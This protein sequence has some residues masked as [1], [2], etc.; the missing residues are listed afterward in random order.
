MLRDT[1]RTTLRPL[2]RRVVITGLGVVS[3]CGTGK[4]AFWRSVRDGVSGIR[5]IE[6]FDVSQLSS[7]IGGEVRDFDPLDYIE[8]RKARHQGRFVHFCVAAARLALADADLDPTRMEPS[9]IGAAFGSSGAGCGNIADEGYRTVFEQ[10]PKAA[11]SGLINE[12][13]AHAATSHVSIEFGLKGPC[14]SNSTGCV[15]SIVSVTNGV[16][17]LRRG[18]AKCMVVGASEACL[19]EFVFAVLC[20]QRVLSTAND[21][22]AG[23]CKPFDLD[24]DG[25][26]LGEGGA[27]LVLETA[28]HAM[29]RGARIYGEVVGIGFASEA[30]HMVMSIPT[31]E[32]LDRALR[33][34]LTEAR[35][36]PND[37]DYVCAHG[38]GN[39]QYDVADTRGYKLALGD[40]AYNIPV[41]SIK[42]VTAQPFAAA[43]L[44]QTLAAC[45]SFTEG[46]VPPT[47]NYKT[48]DPDCDLDYVPNTA[49]RARV[50]T[51]ALNSHSF[52]GTHAAM[53]LRRFEETDA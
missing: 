15:T 52:G 29:D 12:I 50:D 2:A 36:A 16:Q 48:P 25:L 13:P 6:S 11:Y 42:P 30:Y 34:A 10:G 24:R 45:M 4:D 28:A 31:G 20:R 33:D 40:H 23:A 19:S 43:G 21:D 3:C 18:D 37:V 14:L 8:E 17:V 1:G 39:K 7:Q 46:V 32:E 47:I 27:A 38:I 51:A 26:V 22:P 44:M 41:S 49:R 9:D 35:L 53:V 5:R